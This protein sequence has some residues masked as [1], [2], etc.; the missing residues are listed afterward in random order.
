MVL[1]LSH[2]GPNI[3]SLVP[4][5]ICQSVSL[6]DLKSKIKKW[7][8]SNCH[9]LCRKIFTSSRIHL[10]RFRL[11]ILEAVSTIITDISKT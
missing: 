5:E 6:G 10:E 4:Q 3:W 11:T 2:L 9:R 8:S 1:K 7:T